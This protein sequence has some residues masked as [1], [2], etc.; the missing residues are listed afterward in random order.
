MSVYDFVTGI[1]IF[2]FLH[3]YHG[4]DD[5]KFVS[6]YHHLVLECPPGQ[7]RQEDQVEEKKEIVEL[8]VL[9]DPVMS[10]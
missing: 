3:N 8:P 5:V 10:S 9:V 6:V 2:L 4:H 7:A 1:L